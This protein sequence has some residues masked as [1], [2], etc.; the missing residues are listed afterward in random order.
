MGSPGRITHPGDVAQAGLRQTMGVGGTLPRPLSQTRSAPAAAPSSPVRFPH[1]GW[2][3]C[4]LA[5][6]LP[7]AG[8]SR[9]GFPSFQAGRGSRAALRLLLVG[10]AGLSLARVAPRGAS[11]PCTRAW[12]SYSPRDVADNVDAME[13]PRCRLSVLLNASRTCP[14]P[15]RGCLAGQ[16]W[17]PQEAPSCARKPYPC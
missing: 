6:L 17:L 9:R 13:Q 11:S 15:G 2:A 3:V 4:G 8:P 16:A 1:S 14:S 5:V 10:A 12:Y 7:R